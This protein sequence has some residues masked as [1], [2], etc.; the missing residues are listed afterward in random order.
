MGI[1]SPVGRNLPATTSSELHHGDG[2]TGTENSSVQL[3]GRNSPGTL[4]V[5]TTAAAAATP[6]AT[7][8]VRV[9]AAASS[10][11]D[12]NNTQDLVPDSSNTTFTD[13]SAG[14]TESSHLQG[15]GK[16]TSGDSPPGSVRNSAVRPAQQVCVH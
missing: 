1:F 6:T 8:N 2:V 3:L 12:L 16:Q 5:A 7:Q 4:G 13:T 10:P 11:K 15:D 14:G 9:S